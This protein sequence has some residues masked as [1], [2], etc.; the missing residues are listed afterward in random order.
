[1][2]VEFEFWVEIVTLVIPGFNDSDEEL[3]GIAKFIAGV[4][5]D[6]PWHVTAFHP[7]YKMQDVGRTPGET[8]IRAYDFGRAAGLR[9]VY[10]GNL[11]GQLG[12]RECTHCPECQSVVIRRTGFFV[13]ENRMR[14]K[15]KCPDCNAAIPGVWEDAPPKRS[16]GSGIPMPVL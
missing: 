8:L 2:L 1:M 9:Y 3:L 14:E 11:H 7:D 13:N 4:S 10:P 6:I 16:T 15:G 12:D 5:R